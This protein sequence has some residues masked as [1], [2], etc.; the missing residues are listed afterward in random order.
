MSGVGR[1]FFRSRIFVA[2]VASTV[3]ALVAGGVAWAVQSPVDSRGVVHAC[4]NPTTGGMH[5]NVNRKR[6][7]V[8]SVEP[9]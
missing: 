2:C 3:T 4:Y 8:G 9:S 6:T 1:E 7:A 5:L